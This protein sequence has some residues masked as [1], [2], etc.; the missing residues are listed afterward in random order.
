MAKKIITWVEGMKG[1][2]GVV[3]VFNHLRMCFWPESHDAVSDDGQSYI[4]QLPFVGL[5]CAGNLAV[6]IYFTLS[7]TKLLLALRCSTRATLF[8]VVLRHP[9][10]SS[11]LRC[12]QAFPS[13]TGPC[14]L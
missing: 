4:V 13:A 10:L 9:P 1:V 2:A 7:G 6:R 3:I 14:S 5:I 12:S 8:C 11:L